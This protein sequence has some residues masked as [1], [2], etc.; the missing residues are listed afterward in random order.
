M[1]TRYEVQKPMRNRVVSMILIPVLLAFPIVGLLGQPVLALPAGFQEFY[2]P[3]PTGSTTAL[4]GTYSVFNAMNP[5]AVDGGMH[6]IVGV[7]ASQDNT[8]IYYDHW[9]VGGLGTG[10]D[11][12]I[13]P[14]YLNRGQVAVFESGSIPVP[15]GTATYYDGGDRIFVSGGLLQLVV[16]TWTE[17]VQTV[18][19][20]AWEVYPVQ[21]WQN[22]YVIPVGDNLAD[23]PR[24]YNDFTFVYALVMSGS[25][26]NVITVTDRNG[27][28]VPGL[29]TTLNRGQTDIFQVTGDEGYTVTGTGPIQMQLM[30]GTSASWEMRGYTL[31]PRQ[32]WGNAYFTP[33]SSGTYSTSNHRYSE[34]YLY[35]PNGN[36]ISVTLEDA[37]STST[38]SIPAKSTR[39]YSEMTTHYIPQ[40]SGAYV[41]TPGGEVFWG[42]GAGDSESATWDW[43]YDLIPVNFLGTDNYVSWAPCSLNLA[44]PPNVGSPVYITALYDDTTVYVDYGPNDGTFD[45]TY[46]DVDR[47]EVIKI[48]DPDKDNT[49]MHIVS[50]DKLA[51]AWGEDPNTAPTGT[52]GLDMGYTTLPLPVE[53]IDV[54]LEVEKTADPTTILVGEQCTFTV[55]VSVPSTAGAPVVVTTITDQLPP[56]WGYISSSLGTPSSQGGSLAT[57]W[58]LSWTLG[59]PW[60]I[61]PGNSQS[62]T[63]VGMATGGADVSAPN[64][65]AVAATGTSVGATLTAD[66]DAF[67][68]VSPS[69]D[70]SLTKTVDDPTP[71]V[72]SNVTFTIVVSNGGPSD[73]TG[74]NVTDILPSGLT[75]VSADPAASYDSGTGVWTVGDL[76]NGASATLTITATASGLGGWGVTNTAIATA[77]T[78]DP[79]LGNNAASAG[80]G[81]TSSTVVGY[82]VFAVNK[83]AVIA[84]WIALIAAV[85]V[86][87]SLLVLRRRR[88]QS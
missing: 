76:A 72:G 11:H 56:Y 81:W 32:Y 52:P 69:A 39:S 15:R 43:G 33:V 61:N 66:D 73:A 47:F 25:D 59:T 46:T 4:S 30:T 34:L 36:A 13:A 19:T 77:I 23:A 58:L 63:V 75:F 48:Y 29:G 53:W 44:S 7:T 42:I 10:T 8:V 51:V 26:F 78:G 37:S 45:V 55:Q 67:V 27:V 18:F 82:N 22:S 62:F 85:I 28:A 21:A 49:G 71:D 3:L 80:V 60:T 31:T 2:L 9:E 16:S 84:P 87:V 74:V 40:N 1:R 65:N 14:V 17:Q 57:G 6:Y 35:N 38:Y 50:T 64:R 41:H 24:D 83:V 20:D 5:T 12:D 86:G 68:T 88:A 79:A 70:L 54:A